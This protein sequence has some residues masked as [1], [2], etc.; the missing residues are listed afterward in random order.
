MGCCQ[1]LSENYT[2]LDTELQKRLTEKK[3]RYYRS[4]S[5]PLLPNDQAYKI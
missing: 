1:D 4:F 5:P 2:W 3:L